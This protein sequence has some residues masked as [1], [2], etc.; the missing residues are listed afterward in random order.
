MQYLYIT[1]AG[2]K[3]DGV[4]IQG[5][6]QGHLYNGVRFDHVDSPTLSNCT[7]ASI[8]GNAG[9]PPGETFGVNFQGSTGTVTVENVTVDGGNVGAAAMGS[10][11]SGATYNIT[12]YLAINNPYSA[13][14]ASWEHTGTMNF[15]GFVVRNGARAFNAE[16]LAGTVNFYDPLWDDPF[17]GHF[18]VNP[19]YETGWTGGVLNFWF[20]SATA[21]Q[22]FI[23]KRSHKTILA[24]SNPSSVSVGLV[25][26]D[27]IRVYIG[28]VR[29]TQ[30]TYVT[31]TG[32]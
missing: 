5:T 25:K 16:R 26:N 30:S 24:V 1:T 8:P 18:D 21:W 14:W 7:I 31:W 28:G 9:S 4:R 2:A 32:I 3:I 10:N 12:N 20:S 22:A 13:G 6:G 23:A 29:Q 17:S 15:H 19:T 27:V 11:N